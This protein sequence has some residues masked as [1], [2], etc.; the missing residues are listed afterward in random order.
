ML[1]P[2]LP[3]NCTQVLKFLVLRGEDH[4]E[5][6]RDFILRNRLKVE[7]VSQLLAAIYVN[8]IAQR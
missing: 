6:A 4:F 2:F 8:Q 7:E 3:L 5:L 1:Y